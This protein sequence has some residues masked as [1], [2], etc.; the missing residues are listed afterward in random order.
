M[1][2]YQ[3]RLRE[4]AFHK[5]RAQDLEQLVFALVD[6]LKARN[7]EVRIPLAGQGIAGDTFINDVNGGEFAMRL[8]SRA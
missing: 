1:T 3:R 5:Q 8:L 7:V 6:D 4:I 2:S